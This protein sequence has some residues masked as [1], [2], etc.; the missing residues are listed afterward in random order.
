[1]GQ[2]VVDRGPTVDLVLTSALVAVP[3]IGV[4]VG[5]VG[6]VVRVRG[7]VTVANTTAALVTYGFRLAKNG[8]AITESIRDL[9]LLAS[10]HHFTSL[11]TVDSVALPGDVYTFL[12]S[13]TPFGSGTFTK[14]GQCSL[15][16]EARQL[17]TTLTIT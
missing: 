2:I 10:S 12:V 6:G 8:M 13:A 15:E 3:N 5:V 17:G 7:S 14:A 4:T 16:V 1:M 9:V 11:E